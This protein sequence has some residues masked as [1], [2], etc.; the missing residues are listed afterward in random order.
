MGFSLSNRSALYEDSQ[1]QIMVETKAGDASTEFNK[2]VV[3]AD[4]NAAR[5]CAN[6]DPSVSQAW[7]NNAIE[8]QSFQQGWSA[9]W[10]NLTLL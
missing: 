4:Q 1:G 5:A 8:D 7:Q 3:P 10:P 9:F 2:A 6:A